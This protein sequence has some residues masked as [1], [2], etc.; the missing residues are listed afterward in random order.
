VVVA[1]HPT[2]TIGMTKI[3]VIAFTSARTVYSD[4]LRCGFIGIDFFRGARTSLT[5]CQGPYRPPWQKAH[6][7]LHLIMPHLHHHI[8][9]MSHHQSTRRKLF[10]RRSRHRVP[11][12]LI[13]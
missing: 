4:N 7:C 11:V 6:H 10:C 8:P 9:S 5:I 12:S 1:A 13:D 2:N 3:I